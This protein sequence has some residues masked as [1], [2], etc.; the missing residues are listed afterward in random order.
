MGLNCYAGHGAEAIDPSGLLS[1]HRGQMSHDPAVVVSSPKECAQRCEEVVVDRASAEIVVRSRRLRVQRG[2]GRRLRAVILELPET[3][4]DSA[5][6]SDEVRGEPIRLARRA[7]RAQI[8]SSL[9]PSTS[10]L[11]SA[12]S[13]SVRGANGR[14][15]LHSSPARRREPRGCGIALALTSIGVRGLV[16]HHQP[17]PDLLQ[18]DDELDRRLLAASGEGRAD[19]PRTSAPGAQ[20]R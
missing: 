4:R 16:H 7:R 11:T 20:H 6:R 3:L 18:P 13:A 1:D 9:L 5:Q 2:R 12:C 8:R 10:R 14:L 15:Q 19:P 17:T